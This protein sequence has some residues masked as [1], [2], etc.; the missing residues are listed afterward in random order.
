MSGAILMGLLLYLLLSVLVVDLLRLVIKVPP[1][2]YGF[3]V[4]FLVSI[5][6]HLWHSEC[7]YICSPVRLRWKSQD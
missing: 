6:F 2:Y 1:R 7:I 5:C 4:L 3:A